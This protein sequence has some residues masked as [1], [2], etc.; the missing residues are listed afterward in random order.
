[1]LN[2][3]PLQWKLLRNGD[4]LA[5]LNIVLEDM[6]YTINNGAAVLNNTAV[7]SKI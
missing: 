3:S 6:I 4:V 5:N 7:S 1:M 2:I